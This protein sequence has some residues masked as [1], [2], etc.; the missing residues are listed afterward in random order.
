MHHSLFN[1]LIPALFEESYRVAA[2]IWLVPWLQE[3]FEGVTEIIAFIN[4]L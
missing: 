1:P 2:T 3:T 4:Q